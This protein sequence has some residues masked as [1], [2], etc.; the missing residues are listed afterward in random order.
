MSKPLTRSETTKNS[1]S[2]NKKTTPP[3]RNEFNPF[4]LV[5]ENNPTL[6]DLYTV[7]KEMVQSLNFVSAQYEE[8]QRKIKNL[9]KENENLKMEVK[10][11]SKRLQYIETDY[12]YQQQ[13]ELQKHITIHGVPK[14]KNE[15]LTKII[16][17]IAS[18][19]KVN[20][21]ETDIKSF[22]TIRGKNNLNTTPII[23]VELM[24]EE[25]KNEINRNYKTNGPIIISQII[26]NTKNTAAE[27]QKVYINDYLCTYYKKLL[28]ETKKLK[29]N[30]NIK[31]VWVKNGNIYVRQNESSA[32]YRIRNYTDLDSIQENLAAI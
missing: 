25:K 8:S 1:D 3:Q 19:L 22:R 27:H 14:Q 31:F 18:T 26:K 28:E 32:S 24:D 7:I 9:E 17:N 12:Y 6:K 21:T 11:I 30:Y 2:N 20:I 23:V 5:D 10:Q 16:I 13:Q 4:E 29:Q 15:D